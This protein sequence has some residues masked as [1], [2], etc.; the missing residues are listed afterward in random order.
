MGES[1]AELEV[2]SLLERLDK[3]RSGFLEYSGK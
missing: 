2:E 1:E 3:N